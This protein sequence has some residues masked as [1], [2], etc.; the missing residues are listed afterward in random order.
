MYEDNYKDRDHK[1]SNSSCSFEFEF[2]PNVGIVG[3]CIFRA[4]ICIVRVA[5]YVLSAKFVKRYI[6][7][8]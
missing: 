1:S 4:N 7:H 8:D 3:T 6:I 2:E 5:I